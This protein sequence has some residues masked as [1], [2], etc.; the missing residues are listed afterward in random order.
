M[1]NV[2]AVFRKDFE[3]NVAKFSR[4]SAKA[5]TVVFPFGPLA[6]VKS[7]KIGI[8]AN[9]DIGSDEQSTAKIG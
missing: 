9:S 7:A 6:L 4:N 3:N 1:L 8:E 5:G 2:W